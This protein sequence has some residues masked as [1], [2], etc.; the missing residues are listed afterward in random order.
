M[1][2]DDI[3]ERNASLQDGQE[4][5]RLI[6]SEE[7]MLWVFQG[8]SVTMGM[9]C[10]LHGE[11]SYTDLWQQLVRWEIRKGTENRLNDTVLNLA[12][13]A[14]TAGR[15]LDRESLCMS[16][17][18]PQVIFI[19]YGINEALY[20]IS[21]AAYRRALAELV[22]RARI[23]GALPV[24]VVPTLTRTP[25]STV[26]QYEQAVRS[27]AQEKN[28]LLVD[29]AAVWRERVNGADKAP[30]AW[31]A[32]DLHPN[33]VGHRILH[34][35]IAC[36]LNIV[37]EYSETLLLPTDCPEWFTYQWYCIRRLLST[38]LRPLLRK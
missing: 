17:L 30:S 21:P 22:E 23:R 26:R 16:S 9:S 19:N 4:L 15:F 6:A 27:L 8:D 24:L 12:Q 29:F 32:D 10:H 28:V 18:R 20:G 13:S 1:A 14:E 31:M 2:E 7:P 11:R 33:A 36:S 3:S 5:Q 35:T 34:R 38:K 25:V 37:P